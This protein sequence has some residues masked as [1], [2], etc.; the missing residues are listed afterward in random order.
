MF[1]YCNYIM[2]I[3]QWP[4]SWWTKFLYHLHWCFKENKEILFFTE[5]YAL[6]DAM[7][8]FSHRFT[9]F[10]MLCVL[11]HT[12]LRPSWCNVSFFTQVY[13]S[14]CYVSLFTQVY[15]LPDTM[16]FKT[17]IGPIWLIDWLTAIFMVY[18]IIFQ[19]YIVN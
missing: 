3:A 6:H 19:S 17:I 15:V 1:G 4:L 13:V 8:P 2:Y 10:M 7:C 14:W 16:S 12:G 18:Y 5:F 9:S 11:F